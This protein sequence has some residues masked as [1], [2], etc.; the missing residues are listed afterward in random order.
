MAGIFNPDSLSDPQ[1]QGLLQ[2]AFAALQASGPSR[3]PVSFGQALGQAGS[4]GVAGYDAGQQA[5]LRDIQAQKAKLDLELQKSLQ[6]SGGIGGMLNDPDKMEAVG[7]KLALQGHPGGAALINAAEK[8]RAKRAAAAQFATMKQATTTVQPDP[9]ETEQAADQGTP[10]VEPATTQRGGLFA[11]LM[12]SPHVGQEAGLLQ[13]QLNA[14][15]NAD[16]KEWMGHY[17]RLASA[18]RTAQE[19]ANAALERAANLPK[20]TV[21][22]ADKS[23]PTGWSHRDTRTDQ[24]I[25]GAPPPSAAAN[26][27][28]GSI[29]PEQHK[30]I[31]GDD[32]LATLPTG[33]ASLVK[34]ISEGRVDPSKAASMRFGNREA[35]MQRV[36]QYDPAYNQTRPKVYADFT[37]GKAAQNITAMN[38]VIAH[39]GTLDNLTDALKNK[40]VQTVNAIVNRIRTETGKSEVNNAEIA[41]QAVGNELM[42]V[43]RQVNASQSEVEAWERKFNAAKGSP[44]QIKGALKVGVELLKG[45][46]DAVNDQWKRGMGTENDFPN[47][48]SPKSK[49]VLE[50]FTAPAQ[51]T[52][53][54]SNDWLDKAMKS[55]PDMSREDVVAE[56]RRR[57]KLSQDFK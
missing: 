31:H 38:T 13:S 1:T 43:F 17:E 41:V 16:P 8:V 14:A 46:I 21:V 50:R 29:V 37:T 15:P 40:D 2:A 55:N 54:S 51:S 32:Y 33:M 52:G 7:T 49:S 5:R 30:D 39:I 19:H 35:I 53:A 57:G 36:M 3:M 28:S 42:R 47:I 45:R 4:A 23:S 25:P 56:G 34:S 48:M 10:A 27:P 12:N 6:E 9:Q 24:I 18:H 26:V 22:I 11:G 20:S 44:E